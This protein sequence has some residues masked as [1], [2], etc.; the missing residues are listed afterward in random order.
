MFY[1]LVGFFYQLIQIKNKNADLIVYKLIN[2]N[3]N[4]IKT[5]SGR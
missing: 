1:D 4:S 2:D 3:Y 5:V